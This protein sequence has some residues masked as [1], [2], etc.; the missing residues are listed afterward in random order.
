MFQ[1][2]FVSLVFTQTKLQ[3]VLLN[4]R[5]DAVETKAIY[6]I[7]QGL[8]VNHKVEKPQELAHLIVQVWSQLN[9]AEKSVG[10]VVPEFAT[11]T[12][13]LTLPQ[14][15]NEELT[16]AIKWQSQD[17]LPTDAEEMVMDWKIISKNESTVDV[18]VTAIHKTVLSGFVDAVSL[19][20]LYPLVVETPSLSLARLAKGTDELTQLLI[21]NSYE[22]TILVIAR[23]D[24]IYASSVSRNNDVNDIVNTAQRLS[25]HFQKISLQKILVGGVGVEQ[26]MVNEL[27]SRLNLAVESMQIAMG[28]LQ[29]NEL[30]EYLIAVSNQLKDPVEPSDE[31]T[32]NLLPPSWA[33]HYKDKLQGF[34]MWTVSLISSFVVWAGFLA[35]IV[36]YMLLGIQIQSFQNGDEVSD[37]TDN[38]LVVQAQ[39]VND[40]SSRIIKIQEIITY[41]DEVI[42]EINQISPIGIDIISYSLDLDKGSIVLNGVAS[43]RNSLFAFKQAIETSNLYAN[44]NLPLTNIA[45]GQN[46]PFNISFQLIGS[47]AS[48]PPK[49]KLN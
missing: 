41:P 29:P 35:L 1:K 20:G 9:L 3:V 26:N 10:I 45:N 2:N 13:Q 47:V 27:S 40:L 17:F 16:E 43:D 25:Q 22:E 44:V 36:I 24:N 23:G 28:G 6:D 4:S 49:L 46:I 31:T 33:K 11:Y 30:H 39:S 21:Y 5:K 19:A 48:P 8:I 15:D 7:P 34:E 32:V 14:L 18:L 42:N 37:T 12:K 38:E